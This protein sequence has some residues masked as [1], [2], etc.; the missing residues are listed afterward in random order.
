MAKF[1]G[2]KYS[3]TAFNVGMLVVRMAFGLTLMTEGYSLF[4]NY[5]SLRSSFTNVFYLGGTVSLTVVLI[6][7]LFGGF[8]LLAGFFTR[9]AAIPVL[10]YLTLMLF[11]GG[12]LGAFLGGGTHAIYFSLALLLLLCGPGKA[13]LDSLMKK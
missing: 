10:L 2:I 5:S 13:S 11:R 6:I 8:M 9:Y 3:A 12:H 7:E 1:S 4:E